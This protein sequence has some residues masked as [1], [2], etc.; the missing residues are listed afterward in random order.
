MLAG[1]ERRLT[2][3]WYGGPAPAWPL[4]LLARGVGAL[5]R[6]R[7]WAYRAGLKPVEHLRVPVLVVGNRTVGGAGKTPTVIALVHALRA[8]GWRPG[9]VS[10]GHGRQGEGPRRVEEG[11]SAREVG[12]EPLLIHH[13]TG[14]PVEVDRD[15]PAAARRLVE[16]GC[17][18][19]I[20]DDG[21]QHLRLGRL[22]EVEVQ[23]SRGLGNGLVL[24][25]GPLREPRPQRAADL[26]LVHGRAAGRGET[27]MRLVLGD[28][29]RLASAAEVRPLAAFAGRRVHAVAGIGH[30]P[31]FFAA[32]REAGLD[33]VEHPFPD[34]HAFDA[35]DLA[36]LRDAPLLMTAK[37]AVKCRGFDLPDA[38]EVPVTARIPD[39]AVDALD[40]LLRTRSAD[41][42]P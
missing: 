42:D 41:V 40:H 3:R 16:A 14:A 24:P 35:D 22:V 10:R 9:V 31:R 39:D 8:R 26:V 7:R 2:A 34:H 29:R 23:D 25:A 28:A 11:R 12:D 21:L 4:R 32:L 20:A 30:P 1:L 13:A 6:L 18:L 27:A 37:D 36:A 33:V 15:R 5:M 38:W 17:T 19:V